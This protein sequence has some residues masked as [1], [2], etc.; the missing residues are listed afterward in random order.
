MT[1][2]EISDKAQ[3]VCATA[4]VDQPFMCL[5]LVYITALLQDG[6]DLRSTTKIKVNTIL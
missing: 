2:E 3:S 6:Y 4:N 5:D 1:L